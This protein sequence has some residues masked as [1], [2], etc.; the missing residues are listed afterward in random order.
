MVRRISTAALLSGAASCGI[1]AGR[2]L[3]SSLLAVLAFFSLSGCTS[4]FFNPG[5][6][7][8]NDP[9]IARYA[10]E[11][12]RF[13]SG[14]GTVLTGWY[15]KAE[16]DEQ[17]TILVC[18]GNVENMSTHAKLDLW[19][20]DAGYNVFIFD[21]RGYGASEGIPDV[22]GL[23]LDAEAALKTLAARTDGRI[24]TFGKSL[25]GAVAVYTL[26]HS[27]LRNRVKGLII[28]S[29]FSSYRAIA[30]D[31]IAGSIIGWPFQYPLSFLVT[32]EYSP[33]DFI[34]K[35][36]PIPVLIMHGCADLIVPQ[37]HGS[38]L[39]DAALQPKEYWELQVPGHVRSWTDGA[40]RARLLEYLAGLN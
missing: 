8:V 10:P 19:L 31:K 21:Y 40:T 39:Y 22:K 26:A 23:H 14:D 9:E 24:I 11:E 30:R 32:D 33:V 5:K 36:S 38:I 28:E 12:V 18:H 7:R 29:A 20:I 17:G 13:K 37:H 2:T 3:C 4:F 27:P 16:G 6:E 34:K 15:F 35:I 25:G 1:D